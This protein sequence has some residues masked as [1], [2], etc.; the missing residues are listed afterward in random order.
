MA[1][2]PRALRKGAEDAVTMEIG[3]AF[4]RAVADAMVTAGVSQADLA[5]R[6]GIPQRTLRRIL[7]AEIDVKLWH[8][9]RISQALEVPCPEIVARADALAEH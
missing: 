5:R 3:P 2:G 1:A 9:C 6:S 8:V 4:A 7:H